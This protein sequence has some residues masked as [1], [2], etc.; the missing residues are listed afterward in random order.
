MSAAEGMSGGGRG[1]GSDS[2][3]GSSGG[4][5]TGAF[6]KRLFRLDFS[7]RH[8]ES[9]MDDELSYHIDE[10]ISELRE[11]GM[12]EPE[13][14]REAHRRFG[15]LEGIRNEYRRIEHRDLE[16]RARRETLHSI[17][18]DIRFALR[19]FARSPAF[20]VVAILTLAIGIGGT[21]AIF[22]I[23]N[24]VLLRP[25]PYAEPDRLVVVWES[26]PQMGYPKMP[27][28]EL[29]FLDYREQSRTLDLVAGIGFNSFDII[30]VGDP[31]RVQG[32]LV[33]PDLFPMLG[34]DAMLGRVFGEADA[35]VGAEP[36]VLLRY[37][38]WRDDFGS[39]PEVIGTS[40]QINGAPY[41]VIGVMPES[42]SFPPPIT[43]LGQMLN[44]EPRIWMPY[45]INPEQ[46]NRS[47]HG[48]FV[49]GRRADG[50][51]LEQ[52]N[53]EVAAIAAGL[54]EEYP[55]LNQG[56]SALVERM[57]RQSVE[58]IRAALWILLGA[59]AF[60]LLIACA[61]V[62]NLLLA[63]AGS[64]RREIAIR[65]SVGAGRGR[66]IRQLMVESLVLAVVGGGLGLRV[67]GWGARGLLQINPIDLPAMF[68]PRLDPRVLLFSIGVT[69][70]TGVI[71][72]L[73]PAWQAARSDLRAL[74][75]EGGRTT[76]GPGRY[77]TRQFL[78]VLETAFTLVLLTGTGLM[79]RSFI[80]LRTTDPGFAADRVLS[81]PIALPE[82]RYPEAARQLDFFT[83]MA[84]RFRSVPGVEEAAFATTRPFSFDISGRSYRVDG[85]SPPEPGTARIAFNRIVSREYLATLDVS[86]STGRFFDE[87]DT[88]DSEQVVVVNEAFVRQHAG[89]DDLLGRQLTAGDFNAEDPPWFRIVGIIPDL[90]TMALDKP[91]DPAVYFPFPQLPN[92]Y[93]YLLVRT[94]GDPEPLLPTLQR[95]IWDTDGGLVID[96]PGPISDDIR[97]SLQQ[98]RFSTVLFTV[99]GIVALVLAAIGLY[100]VVAYAVGQMSREIGIRIALGALPTAVLTQVLKQGLALSGLGI[101]IGL[102]GALF[103]TRFRFIQSSL[104]GVSPTD[105]VSFAA[106]IVILAAVSAAATLIPA[107]R[108]VRIDPVRVLNAQ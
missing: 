16:E 17:V 55:D 39:D 88:P 53:E 35:R 62:A 50:V 61:N 86:L 43:F 98:S 89:I 91:D 45:I 105:L 56:V 99:F 69:L 12:T 78:V 18:Q 92:G 31:K 77:R 64:R 90:H 3:G 103:L 65:M 20:A 23:V 25:L 5:V 24:G 19:S 84:E 22:S 33:T 104:V 80:S 68:Q 70:L 97:T 21:T 37:S 48:M 71:F 49:V 87:T 59:V 40:I 108:A 13:A 106:A 8:L 46:S 83:S 102:A 7:G 95:L 28:S 76:D 75:R 15:N 44:I 67:A 60:V 79:L 10:R 47:Q 101:A 66:L 1:S 57:H 82:Q 11:A 54:A 6:W 42:F 85:E 29:N 94:S 2:V 74:I 52:V 58:Q 41:T 26:A 63:R 51:G 14:S 38:W 34:V 30:G 72:G 81:I 4:S 96:G 100:G 73:T 9:G 32:N 107:R 27:F 93:A 36:V